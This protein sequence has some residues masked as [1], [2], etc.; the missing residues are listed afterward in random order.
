M[1]N[2]L[3]GFIK[4]TGGE[5]T[6]CRTN[7]NSRILVMQDGIGIAKYRHRRPSRITKI[8]EIIDCLKDNWLDFNA[9]RDDEVIKRIECFLI[10]VKRLPQFADAYAKF[11]NIRQKI[12]LSRKVKVIGGEDSDDVEYEEKTIKAIEFQE[13]RIRL[14]D[15]TGYDNEDLNPMSLKDWFILEQVKEIIFESFDHLEANVKQSVLDMKKAMSDIKKDLAPI[16][17]L[18]GTMRL[19]VSS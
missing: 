6:V 9:I 17:M 1:V 18:E 4:C 13:K 15:V 7:D 10:A 16:L 3:S 19:A 14:V 11:S 8:D 2:L 5:I 12:D